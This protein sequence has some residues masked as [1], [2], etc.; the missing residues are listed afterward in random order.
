V[1]T[2]EGLQFAKT[3]HMDFCEVSANTGQHVSVAM[4]RLIVAVGNSLIEQDERLSLPNL[5]REALGLELPDLDD[6]PK[7]TN[8][9]PLRLPAGW[10]ES[11][12]GWENTWTGE[13]VKER[14]T[15][16]AGQG[17]IDYSRPKK[18]FEQIDISF[19]EIKGVRKKL[20]KKGSNKATKSNSEE[21]GGGVSFG[22]HGSLAQTEK[23]ETGCKDA[24][25]VS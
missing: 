17:Q 24:C 14:P 21:D 13:I 4:R 11:P 20:K 23:A 19:A 8:M 9:P 5:D 7:K 3:H 22:L 15:A 1:S 2:L 18:D 10:V 6:A 16:V 12:F 25:S